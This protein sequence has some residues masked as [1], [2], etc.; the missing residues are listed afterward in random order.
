M[1]RCLNCMSEYQEKFE[2]TC[3]YCGYAESTTM[4]GDVCLRP[5]TILQGRY[6]VGTVKKTRDND[7]LYIGWDALF[8]R[9]VLIQEYFPRYCATRSAK[10]DL[11]IY[12]SKKDIFQEGLLLFCA[13]SRELIRLYKERD[14]IT[15]H[16][17]FRENQTAYGVMDYRE[18]RTLGEWLEQE[19]PGEEQA[20]GLLSQAVQAVD[21]VH[22]IGVCHG[23]IGPDT[24]WMAR[25]GSLILKDFGAWRYISGEPGV[26]NYGKT[27]PEADVY[28][29][30]KLFCQMVTG[31]VIE[32]GDN[33]EMDLMRGRVSLDRETV[34]ALK[35]A[36]SHETK[37]LYRFRDELGGRL[38]EQAVD[39]FHQNRSRRK[40]ARDSLSVPRWLYLAA[41]IGLASVAVAAVLIF[42]GVIPLHIGFGTS[43]VEK[44]MVRVP[45][46]VNKDA[47]VAE[48]NL[49]DCGLEMS[50]DK[51]EFSDEIPANMISYQ[52]I[53]ENAFVERGTEI[54][55]NI[56]KGPEKGVIPSV[57]GLQ[58]EEAKELLKKEGFVNIQEEESNEKG[59]YNSVLEISE[60][61]D[62]NVELNKKIVL[63]ICVNRET[64]QDGEAVQT[65]V[66]DLTGMEEAKAEEVLA[67][68]KFLVNRAEEAS[69]K[70]KGTV[71]KQEPAAGEKADEGTY[72]T[73]HVSKGPEPIYVKDVKLLA[74][75]EARSQIEG[76][77]LKV[78]TVTEEYSD[79]VASG[80]V[81][82]QSKA[83][84]EKVE[85]GD[86]IDLVVS[87]GKSPARQQE[88]EKKEQPKKKTQPTTAPQP[89][90]T[91]PPQ[92]TAPAAQQEVQAEAQ[93]EADQAIEAEGKNGNT[94][95]L[96]QAEA[97]KEAAQ[98]SDGGRKVIEAGG[99]NGK[100]SGPSETQKPG[101]NGMESGRT[102]APPETPAAAAS[103]VAETVSPGEDSEGNDAQ[104]N[105]Q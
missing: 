71:L 85:K 50:R 81:I 11:S 93:K 67:G 72:V 28:G 18:E 87:K 98:D 83:Q 20:L 25:D 63:T 58:K 34:T 38:E 45:N 74:L 4:N 92:T 78:G 12:D 55:V 84:D 8:D 77:G 26:V 6:I 29:L 97:Q 80:K 48:K 95:G 19:K 88:P 68:A 39:N 1:R 60:K 16:S 105:I 70:P 3:P 42:T 104:V 5:G 75:E 13:Q 62:D 23:M 59:V 73:I 32:D 89:P 27:G 90:V 36:L 53:K 91:V 52:A 40:D 22:K 86:S 7:L 82:S 35:H 64:P 65:E 101:N 9:R 100:T 79:S 54:V 51:M 57:K 14:V 17:C 94:S 96:S 76:L 66:P 15:Y 102:E 56:S 46:V 99:K 41:G 24:F 47:D 10:S 49:K 21:K 30:A 2:G 61:Q 69:D 103:E 33:L 44:N 31:K 37:S 43:R